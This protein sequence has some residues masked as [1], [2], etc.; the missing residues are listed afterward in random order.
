MGILN[1]IFKYQKFFIIAPVILGIT[2]LFDRNLAVAII[3]IVFL[4]SAALFALNKLGQNRIIFLIFLFVFLFQILAVLFMYYAHFQPF[5][6]GR[7][8]YT[9]YDLYGKEI[10]NRIRSGNFSLEGIHD[11]SHYYPVVV[12]VIYAL[13]APDMLLGQL[14]N[15]WLTA[16]IAVFVYLICIEIGSSVRGAV[17]VSAIVNFYPSL[18]F[19]G[20][21]LVRDSLVALL[22]TAGLYFIILMMKSFSW[23][24]FAIFYLALLVLIHFRFYIG[25]SLIVSFLFCWIF[26]ADLE[27]KKR[28]LYLLIIIPLLGFLPAISGQGYLGIGYIKSFANQQTVA[29]YRE[30]AYYNPIDANNLSQSSANELYKA[31]TD[32]TA[33]TKTGFGNLGL[34]IKNC[35]VSFFSVAFGPF[36]WQVKKAKHIF[37]LIETLPWYLIFLSVV[38]G[39]VS[40]FKSKQKLALPVAL[41]ALITLSVVALYLSSSF[42]T[43]IRIRIPAF[44]SLFCLSS[45]GLSIY[46]KDKKFFNFLKI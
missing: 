8:D 2:A 14:F 34:F 18:V 6:S 23:I 39:A 11:M 20:G 35:A 27:I 19:F 46:L 10:A 17:L 29:F 15:A 12:G 5:S 44:I 25:Y 36:P 16:L 31:N 9:S 26:F 3:F 32:S 21:L 33:I 41:F 37:F 4:L 43:Y 13:T 40:A 42:G 7:G 30:E 38:T 22:A 24:K 45:L 28:L 1:F